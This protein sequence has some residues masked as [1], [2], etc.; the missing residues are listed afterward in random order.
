VLERGLQ[1]L[2]PSLLFL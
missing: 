1:S 2:T